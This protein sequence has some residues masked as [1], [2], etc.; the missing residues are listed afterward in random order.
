MNPQERGKISAILLVFLPLVAWYVGAH[1][2]GLAERGIGGLIKLAKL[3]PETPLLMVIPGVAFFVS[4]I[5]VVLLA[6]SGKSEF[7]GARFRKF[8]RGTQVT[9]QANLARVT[10]DR[11]SNQV[12]IA[13]VPIPS[14]VETLHFMIEGATG[15]GKS[16]AFR[17]IAYM[18]GKRGDRLIVIDPN[19]DIYSK[20]GRSKDVLLNPYDQRTNGWSIFNE[21]RADFDYQ[22]FA[23]SLVGTGNSGDA[24][25]WYAYA[26]LLFTEVS[27]K[28]DLL[29]EADIHRAFHW[30]CLVP[31]AELKAFLKGTPAESLFVGAEKALAST[32][33]VLSTKLAAHLLMPA[34]KF[35]LRDWLDD[36]S[37]GN[38]YI[39]WRED[40]LE[41]LRPLNSCWVDV[42]CSSILSLPEES[43]RATWLFTDE[44]ASLDKLPSLPDL[45]TKGRKHDI[46]VVSGLQSISQVEEIYGAKAAQT[47]LANYRNTL[48][49]GGSKIDATTCEHMSKSLGTHE[50]ERDR[51]V[52][53][54]GRGETSYT[55]NPETKEERLVLASEIASLPDL[56]GYL[57]FA[58]DTPIA[59]VKLTPKD[60]VAVN[61]TFVERKSIHAF[62]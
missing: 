15:T 24:E 10:K 4:V 49:L 42:L 14:D 8:L 40:M 57:A 59:R 56:T 43:T 39:T 13:G 58:K 54:S 46:R 41:A 34:G 53:N 27:K 11:K 21:I 50:V 29:N 16:V 1:R 18:G 7:G 5:L 9:S 51:F 25:E 6:N 55:T 3:T 33:F 62:S 26:R 20:F 17:E 32:R 2:L 61:P 45:L 60:F 31:V 47:L 37:G 38:L 36:A 22:R 44:L 23:R 12:T 28:L 30:C 48:A 52:R 35:S 19:A